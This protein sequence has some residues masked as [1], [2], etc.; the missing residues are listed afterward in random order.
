MES[1]Q[2]NGTSK[3]TLR[4]LPPLLWMGVIF[5]LSSQPG[6]SP[7]GGLLSHVV[8]RKIFHVLEYGMLFLLWRFAWYGKPYGTRAAIAVSL[9]YALTDEFHQTFVPTRYGRL[10]DVLIDALGVLA[11]RYLLLDRVEGFIIGR[12]RLVRMIFQA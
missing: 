8:V 6:T 11:F 3:R 7:S 12:E 9:L 5:Y 4:F 1:K 10:T 2:L